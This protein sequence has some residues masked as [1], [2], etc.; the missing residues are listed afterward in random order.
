M[1]QKNKK[2]IQTI[3]IVMVGVLAFILVML[4][5]VVKKQSLLNNQKNDFI[6]SEF[7]LQ[8]IQKEDTQ[9][10]VESE[11]ISAKITSMNIATIKIIKNDGQEMTL[12]VPSEGA[13]FFEESKGDE[14]NQRTEIGLFQIPKDKEVEITYNKQNNDLMAVVVR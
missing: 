3:L 6:Q 10:T 8:P 13:K 4:F 5:I 11:T 9:V 14:K 12:N 1:E 7:Q 2:N